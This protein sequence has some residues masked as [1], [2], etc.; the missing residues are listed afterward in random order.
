MKNPSGITKFGYFGAPACSVWSG[1]T[2]LPGQSKGSVKILA[3]LPRS[4]TG[5]GSVGATYWAD[6]KAV[7]Q[8]NIEDL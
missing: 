7:K 1:P 5:A 3:R 8:I 2:A 4:E 6:M